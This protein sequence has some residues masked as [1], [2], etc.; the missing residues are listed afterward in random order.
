MSDHA[1]TRT[2]TKTKTKTNAKIVKF[3]W[4]GHRRIILDDNRI[5]YKTNE[6][7]PV[8]LPGVIG[9]ASLKSESSLKYDEVRWVGIVRKKPI[10]ALVMATIGCGLGLFWTYASWRQRDVGALIASV[11][12]LLLVGCLPAAIF[13]RGREFV[14]VASD[15]NYVAFPA[16][17]KRK[18]VRRAL[19]CLKRRCPASRVRWEC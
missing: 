11:S 8:P 13:F 4:L 19:C 9:V 17:R 15:S 6:L 18:Q 10:W 14:T 7:Y 2:K 16:D 12:F 5:T 1:E 3:D